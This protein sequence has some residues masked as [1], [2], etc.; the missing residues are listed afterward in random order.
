MTILSRCL[1][2]SWYFSIS[3]DSHNFRFCIFFTPDN[4]LIKYLGTSK[5]PLALAPLFCSSTFNFI[6]A[7]PAQYY[8]TFINSDVE[9]KII[10]LLSCK[11]IWSVLRTS[12]KKAWCFLSF[13]TLSIGACSPELIIIRLVR[14]QYVRCLEK[15]T[16]LPRCIGLI[17]CY[18][19]S[20]F[21][22]TRVR[23]WHKQ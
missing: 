12:M 7:H 8:T 15:H 16:I 19:R 21:I 4:T 5:K 10:N 17:S 14:L 13:E 23:C 1:S 20:I 2:I 22:R 3:R 6:R 11:Y 9:K 18:I